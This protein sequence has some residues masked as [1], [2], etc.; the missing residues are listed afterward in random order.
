MNTETSMITSLTIRLMRHAD[1]PAVLEIQAVCY[2]EL[3]PE[4]R[5]R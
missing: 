5:I 3:I 2:T 4:Q 1:L